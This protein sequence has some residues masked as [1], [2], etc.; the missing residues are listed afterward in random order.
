MSID[1]VVID[2]LIASE[3]ISD[4]VCLIQCQCQ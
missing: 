2:C 1:N 4:C 3:L